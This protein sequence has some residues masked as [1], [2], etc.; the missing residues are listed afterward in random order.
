MRVNLLERAL[1]GLGR[2]A[3]SRGGAG[4]PAHLETGIEGEDTAF[5]YLRRKGYVIVARR[6]AC[7][8]RPGDVDLIAWDG[9]LLCFF[10]VKTR[11][12]Q[13]MT[14]AESA[15]DRHKRHTLRRLARAYLRH[16]PGD[17]RPEVRFDVVSVYLVPGRP[18][19]VVHFESA[20]GWNEGGPDQAERHSTFG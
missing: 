17:E 16:L 5:F 7:G 11:T 20:F 2:M 12:A 14:P 9:T 1:G 19:E 6:W 4:V 3:R 13:D 10:E 8:E 18:R 15:V